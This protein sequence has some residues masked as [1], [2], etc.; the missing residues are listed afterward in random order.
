MTSSSHYKKT[1]K[2]KICGELRRSVLGKFRR[3][4]PPKK[5]RATPTS[6]LVKTDMSLPCL[7]WSCFLPLRVVPFP[8]CVLSQ[9]EKKKRKRERGY[10]AQHHPSF[11]ASPGA[12]SLKRS[13]A[14]VFVPGCRCHCA[15][16]RAR[17]FVTTVS[18]SKKSPRRASSALQLR[19]DKT[20]QY[21]LN[22]YNP[23]YWSPCRHLNSSSQLK[24]RA[25]KNK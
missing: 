18:A 12:I 9:A 24:R 1:G 8:S 6:Q 10:G 21:P 14:R 4:Y 15:R 16:A 5:K 22:C 17:V 7:S 2:K 20:F 25:L 23:I 13:R 3:V 19:A 11:M